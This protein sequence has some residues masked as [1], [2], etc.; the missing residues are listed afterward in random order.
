MFVFDMQE[1][2][3]FLIVDMQLNLYLFKRRSM[4][5]QSAWIFF[6]CSVLNRSSIFFVVKAPAK[7]FCR[8]DFSQRSIGFRPLVQFHPCLYFV[9]FFLSGLFVVGSYSSTI[10]LVLIIVLKMKTII[11]CYG[12]TFFVVLFPTLTFILCQFHH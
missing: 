8:V 7:I 1:Y 2:S 11:I 12:K 6:F 4:V 10:L 9:C 3:M 5:A